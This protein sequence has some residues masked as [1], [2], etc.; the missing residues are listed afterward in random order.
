MMLIRHISF[1][2]AV[3]KHSIT[4]FGGPQVHTGLLQARF[5]EQR[6]DISNEEVLEFNAFC[7]LL[8]H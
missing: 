2:Q 8:L 6:K 1:L 7:Q 5:V 4:A 3:F